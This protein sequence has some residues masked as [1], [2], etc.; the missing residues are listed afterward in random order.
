MTNNIE[1]RSNDLLSKFNKDIGILSSN[2]YS[3]TAQEILEKIENDVA[4]KDIDR[5]NSIEDIFFHNIY[6]YINEMFSGILYNDV[7]TTNDYIKTNLNSENIKLERKRKEIANEIYKKRHLYKEKRYAINK[8]KNTTFIIKITIMVILLSFILIQLGLENVISMII[9]YLIIGL[10]FVIY[11][12]IIVINI[13]IN[14]NRQLE[15]DKF[16]FNVKPP[17][18]NNNKN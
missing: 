7:K 14:Q 18:K 16:N 8:D 4:G 17:K 2:Q 5:K 9:S 10:L 15:W 3:L 6:D 1:N 13:K 12:V 11:L